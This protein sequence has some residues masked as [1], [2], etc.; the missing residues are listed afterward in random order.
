MFTTPMRWQ[1]AVAL[2]AASALAACEDDTA[3]P[4]RVLLV[5]QW[6]SNSV[7]LVAIHAGAEVQLGCATV[8]IHAPIE[9]S[10]DSTF[11]VVGQLQTSMALLGRLPTVRVTGR[12]SGTRVSLTLPDQATGST[13]TYELEAGVVPPPLEEPICPSPSE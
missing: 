8:I 2:L 13:V 9:L 10:A 3:G 12:M 5:G 1:L 7:A 11:S 4:S 6:G